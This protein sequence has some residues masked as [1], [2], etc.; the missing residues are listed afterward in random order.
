MEQV[1]DLP[2]LNLYDPEWRIHTRSEERPPAK[3]MDHSQVSRALLSNGC[4]VIRGTVEH[5][6]LSP[7]VVVHEG[8]VVRNSIVMTDAVIGAGAQL[9]HCIIDKR[10]QVG[11]G[12]VLGY[13]DDYTANWLEPTRLNSGLTLV[14]IAAQV[15]AGVR[16]GRNVL[17]GPEVHEADFPS[18]EVASGDTIDPRMPVWE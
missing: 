1:A 14:G 2:P 3:I 16:V 15:R 9:D 17:V 13:G 6:V 8:A 18:L 7:G 11:R 4:I 5:S 10:V 12:A